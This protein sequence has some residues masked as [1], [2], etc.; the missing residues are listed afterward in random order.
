MTL[1]KVPDF[2]LR[3]SY[4]FTSRKLARWSRF[5][6]SGTIPSLAPPCQAPRGIDPILAGLMPRPKLVATE[7]IGVVGFLHREDMSCR[8]RTKAQFCSGSV[9]TLGGDLSSDSSRLLLPGTNISSTH[10]EITF[11]DDGKRAFIT[12]RGMGTKTIL[13]GSELKIGEAAEL[14]EYDILQVGKNR[15]TVICIKGRS[16]EPQRQ[17]SAKESYVII[18]LW[19]TATAQKQFAI[20]AKSDERVV[21]IDRGGGCSFRRKDSDVTNMLAAAGFDNSGSLSFRD[22]GNGS[23]VDDA[24]YRNQAVPLKD[25][26]ILRMGR[27]S[28]AIVTA[29]I[30]NP[31]KRVGA[32]KGTDMGYFSIELFMRNRFCQKLDIN[33]LDTLFSMERRIYSSF[34]DSDGQVLARIRVLTT[35]ANIL[36]GNLKWVSGLPRKFQESEYKKTMEAIDY[37]F[38]RGRKAEDSN[39]FFQYLRNRGNLLDIAIAAKRLTRPA[40]KVAEFSKVRPLWKERSFLPDLMRCM[41]SGLGATEQLHSLIR[42]IPEHMLQNTSRRELSM[43]A[44]SGGAGL[45]EALAHLNIRLNIKGV[46]VWLAHDVITLG[47]ATHISPGPPGEGDTVIVEPIEGLPNIFRAGDLGRMHYGIQLPL[48]GTIF[49]NG[50]MNGKNSKPAKH[51]AGFRYHIQRYLDAL[52][53]YRAAVEGKSWGSDDSTASAL[54]STAMAA[55]YYYSEIPNELI[56]GRL[57]REPNGERS[58]AARQIIE[59]IGASRN[60]R[61]ALLGFIDRQYAKADGVAISYSSLL[62]R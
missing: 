34:G 13:N 18:T 5:A 11:S 1:K 36:E 21:F 52:T 33:F 46:A 3:K 24:F 56:I 16:N 48:H 12:H 23:E 62:N 4:M 40:D 38:A 17:I 39:A 61:M 53:G 59:H 32:F 6:N 15:L 58:K 29:V 60:V 22:L 31:P 50:K 10:A 41:D 47:K 7:K 14:R 44:A 2:M 25:Q 26:N 20:V 54:E 9:I 45:K 30:G 57:S 55:S 42:A 8:A 43:M 35:W 27:S 49:I 37:L 28:V 19:D 51:D